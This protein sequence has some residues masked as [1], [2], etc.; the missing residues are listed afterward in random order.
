MME[1]K[2][3]IRPQ[4]FRG[5]SSPWRTR[6]SVGTGNRLCRERMKKVTVSPGKARQSRKTGRSRKTGARRKTRC[7]VYPGAGP[8]KGPAAVREKRCGWLKRSWSRW[9]RPACQNWIR[10]NTASCW[11]RPAPY[12]GR[13]CNPVAAG[14]PL[15]EMPA[16][17]KAGGKPAGKPVRLCRQRAQAHSLAENEL[18]KY[19][20]MPEIALDFEPTAEMKDAIQLYVDACIERINTIRAARCTDAR[21]LLEQRLDFSRNGSRTDS[22][23]ATW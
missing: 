6:W 14:R 11:K 23:P 16:Q 13:S 7:R 21:I 3:T 12:N 20:A 9:D 4:N 10:R 5:R 15:D 17:R 1:I 18:R 2:I 19:L 22:G 8:R